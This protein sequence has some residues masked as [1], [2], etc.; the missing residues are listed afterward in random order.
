MGQDVEANQRPARWS[1]LRAAGR[2]LVAWSDVL[3]AV[4]VA[5][6][7]L[8][9]AAAAASKPEVKIASAYLREAR[10]ACDARDYVT[11]RLCF[12]RLAN[13]PEASPEM[14][15][16]LA[17][18]YEAMGES[19]RA[20]QLWDLLAPRDR[21]GYAPAQ[22]RRARALL[23]TPVAG[24][25]GGHA[26]AAAEQH[27]RRA[28]DSNPKSVEINAL[29]G[30]L[31]MTM[32]RP[33]QAALALAQAA[34]EKPELRMA[35]ALAYAAAGQQEFARREAELA[36]REATQL[37]ATAPDDY[38]ARVRL[39]KAAVFLNDHASAANALHLG[40][41][42]TGDPRYRSR[43]AE[44]FAVWSD[45][46]AAN[47]AAALL[48][49]EEGL[50]LDPGNRP[51]LERFCRVMQAGGPRADQARRA[52]RD[53]LAGG[54]G[55]AGPHFALGIDAWLRGEAGPARL[56][57]EQAA[58]LAPNGPAIANNLAWVLAHSPDADLSRALALAELAL[59]R[60]PGN[61]QYRGTRGSILARLG[62]PKDALPDLEA[63]LTTYPNDIDLHR[64]L[65]DVYTR[66][67]V[68]D[69]AATHRARVGGP[70]PR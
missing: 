65:A 17:E 58:R 45:A 6:L 60:Q 57:L 63:A 27:L 14:V 18:T 11:A 59:D 42:R 55:G 51:L 24:A 33:D 64:D 2:W 50:R 37:L 56:H 1:A 25:R 54:D 40:L 10:R 30:Q 52:L 15:W 13:A 49:L 8:G 67:G 7:A 35:V 12:Q 41:E 69:M 9:F 62:R 38:A 70:G 23:K 22:M 19:A 61:P 4:L 31:L 32:G 16:G 39:A 3:P 5:A 36:R 26:A 66:L 28:L 68:G 44:V 53:L 34:D 43:L 29:L 21:P 20:A 48:R 47:P 46:E